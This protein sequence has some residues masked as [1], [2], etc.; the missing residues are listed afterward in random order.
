MKRSTLIMMAGAAGVAASLPL[1]AYARWRSS[2]STLMRAVVAPAERHEPVPPFS[3]DQLAGLPEPV[4]RYFRR[5]LPEGQPF[6]R[7]AQLEQSG[8]FFLNGSWRPLRATQ[9]FSA[10][11]PGFVW[12]ATISAAPFMPAYVRDSYVNGRAGMTAS[13]MGLYT[14]TDQSG[15][16]ELNAGALIRLLGELAWLPTAL[17]PGHGVT[18]E[19]IDDDRARATL[20]D[21]TTHASLEFRFDDCG[22][23]VEIF[24]PSRQREVKGA[25]IPTPWRVRALGTVM[26]QGIRML[27]PAEVEWMMPEGPLPYWRG[28]I[29][30]ATYRT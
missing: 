26:H 14:L 15:T 20:V 4:V 21:G 29:T 25:Y 12:D 17:L 3:Y 24:A 11:R 5:S 8:A 13:M 22:D 6:I 18:W 30:R 10:T 27:S 16:A 2:T 23:I 1:A 19:P 28:S 7:T 9:V